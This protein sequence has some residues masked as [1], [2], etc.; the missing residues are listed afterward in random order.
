MLKVETF[1]KNH[2]H[3]KA[4]PLI[5][6]PKHNNYSNLSHSCLIFPLIFTRKKWRKTAGTT[7]H[8]NQPTNQPTTCHRYP[9]TSHPRADGIH[10]LVVRL[11]SGVHRQHLEGFTDGIPFGR[12]NKKPTLP[13]TNSSHLKIGKIPKGK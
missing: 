13:E 9:P 11:T 2:Q 7:T 6:P 8:L 5:I 4:D 10:L 3:F 12:L 1:K